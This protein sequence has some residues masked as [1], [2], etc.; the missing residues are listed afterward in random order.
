MTQTLTDSQLKAT[1][2]KLFRNG[3]DLSGQDIIEVT[4][5]VETKNMFPMGD[6]DVTWEIMQAIKVERLEAMEIVEVMF[7]Y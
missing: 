7:E 5:I 4:R 2:T 6:M 3:Y 1:A